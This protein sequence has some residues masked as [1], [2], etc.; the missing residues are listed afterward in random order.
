LISSG[1][2]KNRGER[3]TLADSEG[4][5]ILSEWQERDRPPTEGRK[6][7]EGALTPGSTSLQ[8]RVFHIQ[9]AE[10]EKA[11]SG[12][13]NRPNDRVEKRTEGK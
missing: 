12:R 9:G 7:G 4:G 5:G 6:F 11:G 1:T 2:G 13:P 8:C 10:G 3:I